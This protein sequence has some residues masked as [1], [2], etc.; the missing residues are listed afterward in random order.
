MIT[1]WNRRYRNRN[2]RNA[3]WYCM[4]GKTEYSHKI[5]EKSCGNTLSFPPYNAIMHCDNFSIDIVYYHIKKFTMIKLLVSMYC[6]CFVFVFFKL[7]FFKIRITLL[8][9]SIK[10]IHLLEPRA[11]S[12]EPKERLLRFLPF[13]SP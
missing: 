7:M 13:V 3:L 2:Y 10:T 1:F 9:H 4:K 11:S 6:F 5:N 12:L 8:T